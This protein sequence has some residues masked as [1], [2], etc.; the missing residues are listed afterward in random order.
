MSLLISTGKKF[1]K[2]FMKK[3]FQKTSQKEVSI[4]NV[5]KRKSGRLYI[6]WKGY[7]I[8]FNRLNIDKYKI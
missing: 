5:I 8:L 4:E 3:S 1:L 7:D 6:K 2:H